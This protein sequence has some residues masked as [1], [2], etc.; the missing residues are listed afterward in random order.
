ML[1]PPIATML[2][3]LA[4]LFT[5][6][7]FPFGTGSIVFSDMG[8]CDLPVFYSVWDALHLKG[9]ILFNWN[10]AGGIFQVSAFN[11]IL[12]PL[13]ILFFLICPRTRI[14]ESMSFYVMIKLM[15]SSYTAMLFFDKKF[16]T[17]MHWKALF[18]V[19]YAFNA[20]VLQYYTN[21]AWLDVVALFPIII[22]ALDRLFE[23]RKRAM[24]IIVLTFC[25]MIQLYVSSMIFIFLFI[26]GGL[27]IFF[28]VPKE[29]KALAAFDFGISSVSAILL[30]AFSLIP[31]YLYISE[32]SRYQTA[33]SNGY[34]DIVKTDI[35]MSSYK[36]GMAIVLTALPAALLLILV[37]KFKKEKKTV[38]FFVSSAAVLAVP[39]VFENVNLFWHMGSYINFPMRFAFMLHF[40]LLT[41]ACYAL[42]RFGGEFW[43][44]RSLFSVGL[45]ISGIITAGTACF[46]M[47]KKLFENADM[48]QLVSD[49]NLRA[50]L[51][52]FITLLASFILFTLFGKRAVSCALIFILALTETA[53]YADRAFSVGRPRQMEYALEYIDECDLIHDSLAVPNDSLSRIKNSDA[54]LNT[55]YPLIVDYPSMSNFTH[56]IPSTIKESMKKL[57]YSTIYT[58]VLDVGGTQLTDA[59]LGEKYVLSLAEITNEAYDSLGKA[60][61]MYLYSRPYSFSFG[62]VADENIVSDD[63]FD[64]NVF[65]INNRIADSIA[66]REINLFS[67][68]KSDVRTTSLEQ[69]H[70]LRVAGKGTLYVS[71][72]ALKIKNSF[73]VY[74]NGSPLIIPSLGER[75]NEGY[76]ARFNNG[77]LSL[78]VF[79]N[80]NVTVSIKRTA[81]GFTFD[82]FKA[83]FAVMDN[84]KL[85]SLCESERDK[86]EAEAGKRSLKISAVSENDGD[87][88]FIP[89][90]KDDGWTCTVN[91]KKAETETALMNY[92][93][94]KLE[95]G[96]NE[97]EMKFMPRGLRAGAM[98]S[99]VTLLAI[100]LLWVYNKKNRRGAEKGGRLFSVIEY[101]YFAAVTAVLAVFYVFPMIYTAA[102]YITRL[103]H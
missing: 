44:E 99:A 38:L 56:M 8:Q 48:Y 59:L 88:L 68:P 101:G 24:Y 49:E 89:V 25:L 58:R 36:L 39:V 81:E 23:K 13:N 46:Y 79:E 42:E 62:A 83:Y 67:F 5:N 31:S 97:V 73:E 103:L 14:L 22:Y 50:A 69:V 78:G 57:G 34:M 51:A 66:G 102:H 1:L 54:S 20:Y 91:G 53:V 35:L 15:L 82:K 98:I 95:K 11:L 37:F 70:E 7:I 18:S 85:S 40:M 33:S 100:I 16:K 93:A 86:I 61:D 60:G 74:V 63:I 65:E 19:M 6:D 94:V 72:S 55:N 64:G 76:P 41:G 29:K 71:F 12:N 28:I 75:R 96:E 52:V 47:F 87:R 90:T 32:S 77:I 10:T 43:N 80:E 84:E 3:M 45:F 92:M 4:V 9:G 27:Y 30:S 21:V 2:L 26:V 17:G